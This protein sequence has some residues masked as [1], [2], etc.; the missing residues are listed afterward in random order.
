MLTAGE[1]RAKGLIDRI[2]PASTAM[3]R[4]MKVKRGAAMPGSGIRAEAAPALQAEEFRRR[5]HAAR[6]RQAELMGAR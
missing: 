6:L 5:R 2:E 1:A 4:I 3:A